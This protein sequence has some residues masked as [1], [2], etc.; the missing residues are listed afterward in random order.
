MYN[1][2]VKI[3]KIHVENFKSLS[4]FTFD[5]DNPLNTNLI[6]GIN[7]SGK[8]TFIE[9]F[10]FLTYVWKTRPLLIEDEIDISQED[11]LNLNDNYSNSINFLRN[12]KIINKRKTFE[13]YKQF[14]TV[15]STDD[16]KIKFEFVSNDNK[17][18]YSISVSQN[19][20]IQSEKIE[21]IIQ[22]NTEILFD[23]SK[24]QFNSS[25]NTDMISIVN[26]H[27]PKLVLSKESYLFNDEL[28]IIIEKLRENI[29][30]SY[31]DINKSDE[32]RRIFMPTFSKMINYPRKIILTNNNILGI[33]KNQLAEE[34]RKKM[35]DFYNFA[36]TI[37]DSIL[38]YDIKVDNYEGKIDLMFRFLKKINNKN[39]YIDFVKESSGTK[40]Y[41][42]FFSLIEDMR[43][44]SGKVYFID[45]FGAFMNE[46][47]LS[48][49]FNL[50][51][52]I[53]EQTNNQIFITTHNS[54]LLN[55]EYSKL[56][57]SLKKDW[58]KMRWFINRNIKGTIEIFNL[59]GSDTKDNVQK[60]Y[61][62]GKYTPIKIEDLFD[63]YD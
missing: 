6:F 35:D 5:I 34:F 51:V 43:S 59:K 42:K 14:S 50:I 18:S 37:D 33:S 8:S 30:T 27:Y 12:S 25:W 49:I 60:K 3:K 9:I 20:T 61:L 16:I 13:Y 39:K 11:E 4:K 47:L 29:I 38:D 26:R 54:I 48:N 17:Y 52:N 23:R 32:E 41:Y 24:I 57:D 28:Y 36:I 7:A 58:N 15:E 10:R 46:T 63:Y 31:W 2:Y 19:D 55:R 40:K 45:E 22:N 53:A 21:K 1:I 56:D 62:L 44:N